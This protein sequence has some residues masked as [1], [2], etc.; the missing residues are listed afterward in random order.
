MIIAQWTCEV[1]AKHREGLRR[2]IREQMRDIYLA[3]GCVRDELLLPLPSAKRY[4]PF[5]RN[6]KRTLYVEQLSFPDRRALD[7]FLQTMETD[8]VARSATG[9]YMADFGVRNCAFTLLTADTGGTVESLGK[10]T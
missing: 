6:L 8:A 9:R 4:F 3:H 1:P 5:H 7:R 10:R 2:F